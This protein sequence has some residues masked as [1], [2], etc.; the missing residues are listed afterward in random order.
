MDLE[1]K[2]RAE[3]INAGVSLP[4]EHQSSGYMD[5]VNNAGNQPLLDTLNELYVQSSTNLNALTNIKASYTKGAKMAEEYSA[6]VDIDGDR[7]I[8]VGAYTS[9]EEGIEPFRYSPAEQTKI[10]EAFEGM[11]IVDPNAPGFAEGFGSFNTTKLAVERATAATNIAIGNIELQEKSL[12]KATNSYKRGATLLGPGIISSITSSNS[13][14]FSQLSTIK[15]HIGS[16]DKKMQDI[17][18]ESYSKLMG[19]ISNN[20]PDIATLLNNAISNYVGG[21]SNEFGTPYDKLMYLLSVAN[22]DWNTWS[23][24]PEEVKLFD[25][26]TLA[27]TGDEAYEDLYN[28][29]R[30][31]ESAGLI[32]ND[33]DLLYQ[34]SQVNAGKDKIIGSLDIFQNSDA[35][36]LAA[37]GY[38]MNAIN[39]SIELIEKNADNLIKATNTEN[40]PI[41]KSYLNSQ[42]D[43]IPAAYA[44]DEEQMAFLEEEYGEGTIATDPMDKKTKISALFGVIGGDLSREDYNKM[45]DDPSYALIRWGSIYAEDSAFAEY[46]EKAVT[47]PKDLDPKDLTAKQYNQI[48]KAYNHYYNHPSGQTGTEPR[49]AISQILMLSLA[50]IN[51]NR[52][53]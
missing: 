13:E 22:D 9:G 39:D 50:G 48:L 51:P 8:D 15:N 5:I 36:N 20:F 3:L 29:I 23:A 21:A 26:K 25:R 46:G 41:Y 6:G 37:L 19:D 44:L 53:K 38:G 45:L 18:Q 27:W 10:F 28:R 33:I 34:A 43:E 31:F 16:D 30:Q 42:T 2:Y 17:A 1:N 47:I 4:T 52:K 12:A 11:G 40:D 49:D 32:T 14:I 7:I 24:L 35:E